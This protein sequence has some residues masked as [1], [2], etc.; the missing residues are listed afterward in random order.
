MK[1]KNPNMFLLFLNELLTQR[2]PIP[3]INKKF[4][5]YL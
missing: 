2:N 1:I 3:M 4:L 5:S